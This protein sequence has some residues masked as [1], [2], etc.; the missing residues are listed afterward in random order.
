MVGPAI[1]RG[2][3]TIVKVQVANTR[4]IYAPFMEIC[5]MAVLVPIL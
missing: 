1:V 4:D 3:V 2:P 5:C